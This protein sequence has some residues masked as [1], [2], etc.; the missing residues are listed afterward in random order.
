[1]MLKF[2]QLRHR[3]MISAPIE[4]FDRCPRCRKSWDLFPV[5]R[6]SSCGTYFCGC[7]EEP[8]LPDAEDAWLLAAWAELRARRCPTC[9]RRITSTDRMGRIK[10][11]A[12]K[13]SG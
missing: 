1:M 2:K 6:C 13:M 7:C 10:K 9:T 3:F 11:P 12:R 4:F 8:D 5:F